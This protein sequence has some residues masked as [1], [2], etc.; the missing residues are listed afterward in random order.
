LTSISLFH[1]FKS[2]VFQLQPPKRFTFPFYYTPHPLCEIAAKQLQQHLE[3]Q[4]D[5]EHNFGLD[6]T[7]TDM[8]IGKMFG[9]LVVRNKE[10]KLCFLAAFSGKLAEQNHHPGFVPPV[11]DILHKDSFFLKEQDQISTI[12]HQLERLENSVEL[13]DYQSFTKRRIQELEQAIADFRMKVQEERKQRKTMRTSKKKLLSEAEYAV[14]LEKLAKESTDLKYALKRL[15]AQNQE[16]IHGIK[17]HV[18]RLIQPIKDLKKERKERSNALQKQLF[19]NYRFLNIN[20]EEK[21]LLD[22]F[23]DMTPPAGAGECAAPKLLHYAFLHQLQPIAMAEFW[24]GKPPKSEVRVHRQFYPAC[25]GKCKPILR[26]M[27]EGMDVDDNPFLNN[28]AQGKELSIIYEDEFILVVNKPAEFLSAPGKNIQDSVQLRMQTQYP[29]ATGPMIVHRLDMST[30]GLI[31]VAKNLENYRLLQK[32]FI[33]R[34]VKKRYV[35]VLEGIVEADE[36]MIDF[37]MRV[38]LDNRPQQI[39]CCEYG[40]TA[41]TNFKVVERKEGKTR[42]HFFPITG[43]THQLRLHAAHIQGLGCPIVGDDIYGQKGERL[44]LHAEELTF[45]HPVTKEVMTIKVKAEF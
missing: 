8:V 2:D 14:L 11:F 35:A 1:Q 36:G 23:K 21:H 40:K 33:K 5:W 18:Q 41:R 31:L 26:H 17:A 30:S 27:L 12:N 38:D 19:E 4:Q 32:Q 22:L 43:R 34:K 25:T 15:I 16:R 28:P 7:K 3:T 6:E 29:D 39:I 45:W 24:W 42:I 13:T 44:Y 9:V 37:P 20:G 10:G